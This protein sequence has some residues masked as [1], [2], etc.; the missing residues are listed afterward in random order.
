MHSAQGRRGLDFGRQSLLEA[1]LQIL[2][3]GGTWPGK[4]GGS[5]SFHTKAVQ[6]AHFFAEMLKHITDVFIVLASGNFQEQA[7]QFIGQLNAFMCLHL[8]SMQKVTLVT[9][10]DDWGSGVWVDLP[11]VL[12]KGAYGLVAVIVCDG[13]DQQKAL[14]PLHALGE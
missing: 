13:I 11:D 4:D 5:P 8:A 14:C 2:H 10:N 7:T 3:V 9:H 1:P 12:V 6:L